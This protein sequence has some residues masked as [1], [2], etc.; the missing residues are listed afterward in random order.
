MFRALIRTFFRGLLALVVVAGAILLYHLY[1]SG[2]LGTM[3]RAVEDAAVV[4]SVK[5]AY[6][7]HRDLSHRSIGVEASSGRVLLSGK[8]R[9]EVERS[10]AESLARSVDGVQEVENALQ[11]DPELD[12]PATDVR[13]LGERI[14][15][16]ALLAKIR[17]A[18]RLDRETKA[19]DLDV[20]VT[21]GAVRI[22]GRVPSE[23]LVERVRDRVGTVSG[24]ETLDVELEVEGEVEPSVSGVFPELQRLQ[25]R[26]GLERFLE[27]A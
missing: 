20:H 19:L 4:G 8:V 16:V 10:Q 2:N 25:E 1:R 9:S 22:R 3:Q 15:D 23:A 14:D 21:E 6:A 26:L 7:L 24:V 12:S 13:S 5:A 27:V 17:T 18:L 11:V